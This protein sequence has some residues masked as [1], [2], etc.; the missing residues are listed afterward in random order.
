MQRYEAIEDLLGR[1]MSYA[2]LVYSGDTT[3]PQRAKF[4][5]D[6]Q[7]R[8][9]A[10]SSDLLFF[11]LELNRIDDAVLEPAMASE[12]L[13]RYRPWLE[14]IRKDKP[15]QLDDKLE[16]LFHEKSVTGRAA[17]NRLF[18]E[19]IASLRFDVRGEELTLEPTL[20]MLQDT[21][22]ARAERRR[23]GARARVQGHL[24][25]FTLITNTLAKDKEISDR[26]RGFEDVADRATSPTGSSARWSRLWSRPCSEAYPRLSHRYYALKAQWFGSD[27]LDFWDRN[28][29]LP[30]VAA[31]NDR[32]G[33]RRATTVLSAYAGFSPRHGRHRP[34]LLRRPLDRRPGAARQ[35]ARRLRASDRALGAP[36]RAPQL[37]RQAA[38][39][40]DAGA[41]TRSRRASGARRAERRA[42]GADPAHARRDGL[43]LRRDADLPAPSRPRPETRR[44]ARPCSPPR[45]RT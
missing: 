25:T 17:W 2:G 5:G 45:S 14:D 21:D 7:E 23:R 3:D 15:Y 28:A 32:H 36:L 38:G 26:W 37:S 10:A 18:D 20:N 27:A 44:S 35:G 13:A 43:R 12:P 41:R 29:P 1:L 33:T 6:T 30:R 8:L 24:R 42:Y 9:T 11:T 31:A 4:Y 40:D 16:Q 34:A 19:T 22:G 39:R